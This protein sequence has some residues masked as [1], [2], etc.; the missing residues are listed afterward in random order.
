MSIT[1]NIKKGLDLKITGSPSGNP[2]DATAVVAAEVAMQPDDFI[3]LALKP[4]VK[5]GDSVK[6]GSPLMH[7]KVYTEVAVV[8]PVSGTV[9]AVVR[10]ERRKLL[11][12]VVTPDDSSDYETFDTS[13]S[14]DADNARLLLQRSGLWAF[15]KQR[16]YDIVAR[17]DSQPRD[18]Y[19]TALDTAPLSGN[20]YNRLATH[21][22]ELTAGAQMLSLLTKGAVYIA[23][24]KGSTVPNVAGATMI[25]VDGPH[26][27][28]NAG[29]IIANTKPVNKGETV[30]T[31][32]GFTLARIGHLALTGK[33]DFMTTVAITGS[34]ILSPGYITTVIGADMASLLK[35]RISTE[36]GHKRII[37]GNLLTGHKSNL[38]DYLRAPYTQITVIPEGDDVTEFMGWASISPKKMSISRSFPGHFLFK[39]LFK[40]DARLLGGER[41]MIMSGEYDKVVPM[42]IL[43]EYLVKAIIS[44]NIEQMEALGIYEVA[45]ED[46]AMAEYCC[47][48]KMPLQQIVRDG[49][50]YLRKEL[51]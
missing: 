41:A 44:R 50:D 9:K 7:D 21:A 22:E 18:I 27:S 33:P 26:P 30:W 25:E 46:V 24:K 6:A 35:N 39:K 3:G 48:S 13:M 45:P 40:P 31:L 14:K 43:T 12:I 23:R 37:S 10:G 11:R 5:D 29:V 32:D 34:E 28:G 47:T 1:L 51:E 38:D 19:V 4:V 17:P 36:G 8:S 20:I 49:L 16:P 42:D 2:S 15:I